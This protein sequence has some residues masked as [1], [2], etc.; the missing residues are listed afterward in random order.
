VYDLWDKGI[1]LP[2]KDANGSLA[3][4][5]VPDAIAGKHIAV[6]WVM[7]FAVALLCW[8]WIG[9]KLLRLA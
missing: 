9:R 4:K 3:E 6:S 2:R 1:D 7:L 8:E 5:I